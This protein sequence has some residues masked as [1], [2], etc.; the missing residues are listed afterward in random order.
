MADRNTQKPT[1][2]APQGT[3]ARD[4]RPGST[5]RGI[6]VVTSGQKY[7][8]EAGFKAIKDG[9]KQ[10]GDRGVAPRGDKPKWLRAKMPAA[11][12]SRPSR[13]RSARGA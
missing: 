9:V 4:T 12:S 6:P 1:P 3:V 10:R 8:H 11:R 13:K 5:L 7:A 2:S